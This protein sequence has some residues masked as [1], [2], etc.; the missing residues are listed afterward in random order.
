MQGS[1]TELI[2]LCIKVGT[3]Q[4]NVTLMAM[5]RV[6]KDVNANINEVEYSLNNLQCTGG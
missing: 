5:K 2:P 1:E 3:K 4:N 6:L